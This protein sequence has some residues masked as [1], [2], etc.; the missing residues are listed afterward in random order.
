MSERRKR[1]ISVKKRFY[2]R[3]DRLLQ[4]IMLARR[5]YKNDE[6]FVMAVN[7]ILHYERLVDKKDFGELDEDD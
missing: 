6:D 5:R 4:A 3:S 1:K 2:G 7:K